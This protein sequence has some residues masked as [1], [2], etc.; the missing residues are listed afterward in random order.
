M[1]AII[2]PTIKTDRKRKLH[3]LFALILFIYSG[4]AFA[5]AKQ[6]NEITIE[7]PYVR[8]IPPGQPVS[9]AFMVLKNDTDSELALIK[10]SSDIAE[11]VEL[12]EHVE[13]NGMLKMRQ[14]PKISIAAKA[15]TDLKPGGYHIMLINLKKAIKPGDI[16][17]INLEFD[18][19]TKQT[20]KAEVKKIMM[21]MKMKKKMAIMKKMKKKK[22]ANPMP[23]LM[24]VYMN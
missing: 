20:I 24:R 1:K 7:A 22:H 9:A 12:H 6:A 8:A 5:E 19:G 15:T 3:S 11:T 2:K 23:N 14:V 13:D 10:A 17:N 21:G 4:T 16:I 18:N